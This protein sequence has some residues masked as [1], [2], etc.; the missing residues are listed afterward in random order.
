VNPRR[1]SFLL[2]AATMAIALWPADAAAQRRVVRR[3]AP[4]VVV[5]VG[6]GYGYPVYRPF[7]RPFYSPYYYDPFWWGFADYQFP[8]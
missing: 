7:Y 4:R 2:A 6:V 5:G 8:R 1:L 3:A